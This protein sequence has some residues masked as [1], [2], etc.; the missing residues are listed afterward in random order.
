M[1]VVKDTAQ[2]LISSDRNSF[3]YEEDATYFVRLQDDNPYSGMLGSHG[4]VG[5]G[6]NKQSKILNQ[7]TQPTNHFYANVTGLKRYQACASVKAG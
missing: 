5:L 1:S 3:F 4:I 6:L 7:N 2:A